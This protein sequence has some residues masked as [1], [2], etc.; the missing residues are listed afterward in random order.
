MAIL[1]IF[2]SKE[3]ILVALNATLGVIYTPF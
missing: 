2:T 3:V 1:I